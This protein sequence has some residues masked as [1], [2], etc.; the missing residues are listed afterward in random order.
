MDT[1]NEIG[2]YE[3]Q[4][5]LERIEPTFKILNEINNERFFPVDSYKLF[6]ED[7]IKDICIASD[8]ESLLY[9]DFIH[10]SIE[11]TTLIKNEIIKKT[12]I[13]K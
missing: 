2:G 9:G 13:L 4:Y 6:C 5:W 12:D 1:L 11:G 7:I 8:G 10:L 3:K